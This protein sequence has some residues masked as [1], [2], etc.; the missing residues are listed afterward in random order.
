MIAEARICRLE[1][2]ASIV[3]DG[4][5]V[6]K[7]GVTVMAFRTGSVHSQKL[8]ASALPNPAFLFDIGLR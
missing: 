3:P 6:T 4:P 1:A 8:A 2:A 7:V 5:L